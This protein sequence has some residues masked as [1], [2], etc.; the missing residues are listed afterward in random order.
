MCGGRT[1]TDVASRSATDVS[2]TG[3]DST[4]SA[5]APLCRGW[6]VKKGAGA[7]SSEKRRWF[8][9]SG[10]DAA[11]L[12]YFVTDGG[13]Q[14]GATPVSESTTAAPRNADGLVI[15]GPG[16]ERDYL[17]TAPSAD[18]RDRWVAAVNG[19]ARPPPPPE[20][21]VAAA[22]KEA[23]KCSQCGQAVAGKF[24]TVGG[25]PLHKAC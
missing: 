19:A 9:L 22:V 18:D 23:P 24:T 13:E 5:G 2:R 20:P 8:E 7:L 10:G 6:L 15:A 1:A 25:M 17:L 4:S 16:L 14:K 3:T 12:R 11:A 21:V